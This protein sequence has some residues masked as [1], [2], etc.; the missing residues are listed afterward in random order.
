MATYMSLRGTSEPSF[1][2]GLNGAKLVYNGITFSLKNKTE[3]AFLDLRVKDLTADA[4]FGASLSLSGDSITLNSDAAGSINDYQMIL[5]RPSTGQ[6]ANVTYT[7]PASPVNGYFLTTDASGNLSWSAISS[8]SVTEKITV[9]ETSISFSSPMGPSN[10]FTLPA[11]AEILKCEVILGSSFFDTAA[12]VSITG[13]T[14]G[15]T[16]MFSSQSDLTD[17]NV[18]YVAE[19]IFPSI[20][21]SEQIAVVFVPNGATTG[22]ARIRVHYVIPAP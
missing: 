5:A 2:I 12:S 14:T 6:M 7:F 20:S 3:S 17:L 16:Y 22:S 19:P 13:V 21:S 11:N 4:I 18:S 15:N 10:F 9:H 8:P 1:L